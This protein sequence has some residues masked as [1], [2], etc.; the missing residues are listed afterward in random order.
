ME[1]STKK[2]LSP[3]V[4]YLLIGQWV[5]WPGL[6]ATAQAWPEWRL[7]VTATPLTLAILHDL[8]VGTLLTSA[9]GVLFQFIPIAFQAPPLPRHVLVWH[10]P[11][12]LLGALWLS[13]GFAAGRW[14]WVAAG[15]TL[16]VLAGAG[17]FGLLMH[18]YQRARNKT[19]VHRALLLPFSVLWVVL[20]LG[21]VQALWPPA[22]RLPVVGTHA[23]LAGFGWW[24]ALVMAL[25]YKLLPMFAVSPLHGTTPG[26]AVGLYCG[27]LAAW[28]AGLWCTS[29]EPASSAAE[30]PVARGL[31]W[32]GALLL[33]A[34]LALFVRDLIR[35]L[36]ASKRQRHV[37][38]VTAALWAS[39]GLILGQV[40]VALGVV[41][42]WQRL[43][44]F[45]GWCM[46]FAG[47]LPLVQAY[48]QKI[49]P[50]LWFEY[51]FSKRP[52][53]KTAPLIDEMVPPRQAR[54]ALGLHWAG[55]AAGVAAWACPVAAS[56]AALA[57][58]LLSAL[59]F[60]AASVV[61][62]RA[63]LHVLTIG[64]PRPPDPPHN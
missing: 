54:W 38:P 8:A 43:W 5:S 32:L 44:A 30:S 15:G 11:L 16:V 19:A 51:R 37:L 7:G 50:F 12:Q 63:L 39:G 60:C 1:T 55:V 62:S 25:T 10:L 6:L 14:S 64:G 59:L 3:T 27:G 24:G 33:A 58:G 52:E 18:S 22:L 29:Y 17:L 2:H 23:M 47:L 4:W 49:V 31:I 26:R 13:A 53:R 56:R 61:L 35:I 34:A 9:W 36:R 28:L 41:A 57:L 48:A 46:L 20:L 40:A 42:G 21:L 45:G